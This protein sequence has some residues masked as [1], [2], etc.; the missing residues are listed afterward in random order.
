[1][2]AWLHTKNLPNQ[3]NRWSCA[4]PSHSPLPLSFDCSSFQAEEVVQALGVTTETLE[5]LKS[6]VWK[7][8]LEAAKSFGDT[9]AKAETLC[10]LALK[11]KGRG[12][13][14]LAS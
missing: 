8:K 11:R 9:L 5:A 1:M 12:R 3:V 14:L 13:A 2:N 6:T 10:K 7:E 4:F